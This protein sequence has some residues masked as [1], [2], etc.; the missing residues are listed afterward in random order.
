MPRRSIFTLLERE[1][2]LALPDN[3]DDLIRYY[4]LNEQDLS[5][6]KQHRGASNQFGFA[7]Q[8]CY[9]RY[10]GTILG[11]KKEPPIY[12]LNYIAEQLN[13]TVNDWD[14]YAHRDQTRR[15]HANEL[16][17]IFG[18]Q[19]FTLKHYTGAL[20]ELDALA[21]QTDKAII[22]AKFLLQ[23]LRQQSILLPTINVIER[24]CS[25]AITQAKQKTYK[26]LIAELNQDQLNQ[27][28]A[29]LTL[30]NQSNT[31]ALKWLRQ[32]P[33]AANAKH[34]MQHI[35]RLKFVQ[36]IM[37][38]A[39]I[40]KQ[41]HHNIL[42]KLAQE[43][44]RMTAQHLRD[45]ENKRRYATLVAVLIETKA[46]LIDEIINL[47]DRIM[48]SVFNKAKHKH[49]E[50]FQKEGKA[51]N[52][53]VHLYSCIGHALLNARETGSAP[54]LA[55]ESIISWDDFT[56]SVNDAQKL[57]Q[58]ENFDY[59]PGIKTHYS[60]IRRY[61]PSFLNI[62]IMKA[63]CAA[64]PIMDAIETLRFMNI[65]N[66]RKLPYDIPPNFIKNRWR[67]LVFTQD[68]IN[69]TFYEFYVLSELRN[70]LRSG[71]IWVQDSHQFKDFDDYLI[72]IN[73][74]NALKAENKTSLA[75]NTDGQKY[76]NNRLE[77][78]DQQ[79]KTVCYMAQATQLPDAV[80]NKSGLKITPL[81]NSVPKEAIILSEQIY[82]MLPR[83]K[84][85]DLLM[86]VDEWTNFTRHF[87][88]I[89]S[90]EI[91]HDKTLMMTVI[92]ADAINLGLTKMAE[93]CPGTTYAKL[94]WLQAWHIRDETYSAS[95]A[96]I[97]NA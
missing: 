21:R 74:F 96:E 78:L 52:H 84:V 69:R 47:H 25:Q 45:L 32:A 26:L 6:I 24:L 11:F 62:L 39:G 76:I 17:L 1:E 28:D 57:S 95:L 63:S 27:L 36:A 56:V 72:P 30:R 2:L 92:L 79:L 81:E 71:D 89:K 67:S 58:P 83:I 13:T 19:S 54:F 14:Q 33:S 41:V 3:Q 94:S 44:F 80:I 18:F 7:I 15:D 97:I 64:Q 48:G 38:P 9:L 4:T 42:L 59:L 61:A 73:K 37:L 31:S 77:L 75:I 66:L 23:S 82:N 90:K 65:H 10:P 16:Q 53:K 70:A 46:T 40:E 68:G 91:A 51:I 49:S 12:L 8:L 86:E 22:L 87:T 50:K 93:S 34:L 43:G 5:I 20:K 35:N 88:H 29:L 85:T 60:Q 55:I